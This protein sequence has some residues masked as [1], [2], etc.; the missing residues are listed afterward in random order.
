MRITIGGIIKC[1]RVIERTYY[2]AEILVR[3]LVTI[4]AITNI[5]AVFLLPTS[6]STICAIFSLFLSDYSPLREGT[7]R[8]S[9][10]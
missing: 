3:I 5:L 2:M 10:P 4:S 9:T 6:S 7:M 8:C 1:N